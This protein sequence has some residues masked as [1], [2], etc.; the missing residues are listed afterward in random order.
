MNR[1]EPPK[2]KSLSAGAAISIGISVDTAFGFA[3]GNMP[4]G[5]A[6]GLA[7]GLL[8]MLVLNARTR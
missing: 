8:I 3:L 7:F 1:P 2:R 6:S 5:L 4:V